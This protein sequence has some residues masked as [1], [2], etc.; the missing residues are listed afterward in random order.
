MMI[1]AR[2]RKA[3]TLVPQAAPPLPPQFKIFCSC[4]KF[5]AK[6]FIIFTPIACLVK[7]ADTWAMKQRELCLVYYGVDF[8][9]YAKRVSTKL[10]RMYHAELPEQYTI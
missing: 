10:P 9:N 5:L 4:S 7:I 8:K 3:A 2:K 6:V 1:R